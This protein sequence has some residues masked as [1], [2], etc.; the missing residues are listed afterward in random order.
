MLD[1]A[2]GA[3]DRAHAHA[4]ADLAEAENLIAVFLDDQISSLFVKFGR[5]RV[6]AVADVRGGKGLPRGE[7]TRVERTPYT[8]IV[9]AT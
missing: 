9:Y 7:K 2:F 5:I 3:L 8:Y 4:E 1:Q 6:D